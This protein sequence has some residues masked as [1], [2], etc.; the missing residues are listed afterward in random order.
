MLPEY[1]PLT[2]ENIHYSGLLLDRAAELRK[3]QSW[4]EDQW[5]RLQCRILLLKNDANLMRWQVAQEKSPI[6]INHSR[7]EVEGLLEQA[8]SKVFLG[9]EDGVPLFATDGYSM[10]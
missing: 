2:S 10:K 7:D 5:N 4:L 6:S 8:N 1:C 3:D 9:L